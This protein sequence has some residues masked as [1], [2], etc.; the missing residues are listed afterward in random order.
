[1]A[2]ITNYLKMHQEEY[3]RY[4]NDETVKDSILLVFEEET[5]SYKE[6]KN[7]IRSLK[8]TGLK[9]YVSGSSAGKLHKLLPSNR[10]ISFIEKESDGFLVQ[11][12]SA[13][14]ICFFEMP[15]FFFVRR[16][17]QHIC[18]DISPDALKT[19]KKKTSY[20]SLQNTIVDFLSFDNICAFISNQSYKKK[21]DESKK[22]V[23]FLLRESLYHVY[24][25]NL[26]SFFRSDVASEYD[27]SIQAPFPFIFE[28][29]SELN[30]CNSNIRWIT[31]RYSWN[32][33]SKTK[34]EY[35]NF[36][37]EIS[38]LKAA[39]DLPAASKTEGFSS[40][41]F[42]ETWRVFGNQHYDIIIDCGEGQTY[43]DILAFVLAP[44]KY[45][46]LSDEKKYRRA[47]LINLN[48]MFN[49]GKTEIEQ[50]VENRQKR[51][52]EASNYIKS[53]LSSYAPGADK[54]TTPVSRGVMDGKNVLVYNQIPGG[55]PGV[56]KMD[57]VPFFEQDQF[58][59]IVIDNSLP[60]MTWERILERTIS[61]NHNIHIYDLFNVL[62]DS[63][64]QAFSSS[65]QVLNALRKR[66]ST[67]YWY[68]K[69]SETIA[70]DAL[71][72]DLDV[73]VLD[74]KG[75]RRFDVTEKLFEGTEKR[76]IEDF[77]RIDDTM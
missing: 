62:I 3:Y 73:I 69:S 30:S 35:R 66:Y 15:D 48:R 45:M 65:K 71:K 68:E 6:V 34:R 8:K 49:D 41:L 4:L 18:L 43:W 33:D 13:K 72:S 39:D 32:L 5:V 10:N 52:S 70:M 25:D 63:R 44:E 76:S 36:K 46:I 74:D 56:T 59:Y 61:Q 11:L 67:C 64:F 60:K 28:Y 7:K 21:E 77:F 2:N 16:P 23:L 26:F 29:A 42:K 55:F 17:E 47:R 38:S 40:F 27:I 24:K 37:F 20:I 51:N 12:A 9:I 58:S 53:F 31:R 54:L 14:Y 50:V 22:R 75:N 1:M 19:K 57:V